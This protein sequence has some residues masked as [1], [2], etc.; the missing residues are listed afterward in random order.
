HVSN[1]T[2]PKEN[3]SWKSSAVRTKVLP[4]SGSWGPGVD[5]T[6]D[7][8]AHWMRWVVVGKHNDNDNDNGRGKDKDK[9]YDND[10][11]NGND[12]GNDN[13]KGPGQGREVQLW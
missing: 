13:G 7:K 9:D 2:G 11:D 1:P 3:A 6:V 8:I 10:Y 5:R 4:A 12:N